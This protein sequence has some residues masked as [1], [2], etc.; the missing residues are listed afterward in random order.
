MLSTM[1]LLM[2]ITYLSAE[3]RSCLNHGELPKGI[4]DI[5]LVDIALV[6]I[7]RNVKL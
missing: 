4:T 1:V 7:S 3:G 2:E 6:N 5:A